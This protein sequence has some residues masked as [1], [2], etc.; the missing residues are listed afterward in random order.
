MASQVR[1]QPCPT[2]VTQSRSGSWFPTWHL[3]CTPGRER[4]L[5]QIS[6]PLQPTALV[7]ARG[8]HVTGCPQ[9]PSVSS[10]LQPPSA[11]A[12][13]RHAWLFRSKTCSVSHENNHQ[14]A[15]ARARTLKM[16]A[17]PTPTP[18]AS[19]VPR[20][21]I[22]PLTPGNSADENSASSPMRPS[23]PKLSAFPEQKQLLSRWPPSPRLHVAES[24]VGPQAGEPGIRV[25]V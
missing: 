11:E 14:I 13:P 6:S 1:G 7:P 23:F 2:P 16:L 5:L 22:S 8:F 19:A 17:P 4:C 24:P 18:M 9:K 15:E 12:G 3:P 10:S 20:L 21:V 25:C